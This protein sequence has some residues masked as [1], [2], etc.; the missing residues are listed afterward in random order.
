M[1]QPI[2]PARG[3]RPRTDRP[4]ADR[5]RAGRPRG[6][7]LRPEPGRPESGPVQDRAEPGRDRAEAAREGR[8]EPGRDRAEPGVGTPP[9]AA[10]RDA[11][12][13]AAVPSVDATLTA[14]EAAATPA[15][16]FL[17]AH[18]AAL[19]V[20]ALVLSRRRADVSGRPGAWAALTRVAPELG[21]WAA[22]FDALALKRRAVEAGAVG[23][24]TSREADDLI[25]DAHAF[26]RAAGVRVGAHG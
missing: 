3:E 10:T 22:Y 5:P 14:A 9:A 18:T 13:P 19:Q 24:V 2:R 12:A 21:E 17:L 1:S 6:E 16:R 20:A 7:T 23:L 8:A 15:R 4:R 26:A 11:P 25:R